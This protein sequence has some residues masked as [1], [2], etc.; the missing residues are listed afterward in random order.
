MSQLLHFVVFIALFFSVVGGLHYYLW[1]RIVRDFAL[2]PPYRTI[3]TA[4]FLV[5]FVSLPLTFLASRAIRFELFRPLSMGPYTWLGVFMLLTFAFLSVDALRAGLFIAKK[6]GTPDFLSA[7]VGSN[8]V[9]LKRYL[10]GGILLTVFGLTVTSLITAA[11]GPTVKSVEILLSRL[12]KTRDGFKFVQISDLHV[13]AT[14]DREQLTSMVEEINALSPDLIAFTGDLVDGTPEFLRDEI[15]PLKDLRSKFGT[16]FVTGNHEYYSGAAQWIAELKK[17]GVRVLRNEAVPI[18]SD[19]DAF[20][21]AG[22]DDYASSGMLPGHGQDIPKAV[23]NIPKGKAVV[24]LAHQPKAIDEASKFGVDLVLSGHTHG[25]QIWPFTGLVRLQ[26]PYN[27]GLHRHSET[28]QIYI[29]QGTFTWGPPM[30]LFTQ[31]EITLIHL[32]SI[33]DV[34]G[35]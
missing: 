1:I 32:R 34:P 26:Q 13:G 29:N 2:P 23:S 12:P 30:R 33:E 28:T 25:G 24:L 7:A 16:F 20:Y 11:K 8:T 10:I 31:N 22:V 27:T 18:G 15:R 4:L 6:I 5:I 35:V 14:A 9:V 21:L 17:L 19:G 3:V